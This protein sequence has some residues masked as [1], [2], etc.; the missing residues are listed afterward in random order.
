MNTQ[1]QNQL[2]RYISQSVT[3][4]GLILTLSEAASIVERDTRHSYL[5]V[6][7]RHDDVALKRNLTLARGADR[8]EQQKFR[9][10]DPSE[11]PT[12]VL[13]RT[14]DCPATEN[15]KSI[16]TQYRLRRAVSW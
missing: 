8:T 9:A 15:Q 12:R 7:C 11:M 2:Y 3:L 16:S 5:S 6:E 1:E 13:D 14:R 4:L 10:V